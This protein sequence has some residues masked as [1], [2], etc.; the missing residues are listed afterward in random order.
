MGTLLVEREGE[1]GCFL[2]ALL[3]LVRLQQPSRL[4][5]PPSPPLHL[6]ILSFLS[7][8]ICGERCSGRGCRCGGLRF[9]GC[10]LHCHFQCVCVCACVVVFVKLSWAVCVCCQ[11][12]AQYLSTDYCRLCLV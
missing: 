12:G 2:T 8:A 11:K 5:L 10:F 4:S 7:L 3:R 6:L 9:F 1:G